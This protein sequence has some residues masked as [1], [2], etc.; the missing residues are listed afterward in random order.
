MVLFILEYVIDASPD[1]LLL[2]RG[3]GYPIVIISITLIQ[4]VPKIII[5]FTNE[6]ALDITDSKLEISETVSETHLYLFFNCNIY[7]N[8][9]YIFL[10]YYLNLIRCLVQ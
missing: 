1:A 4:F 5:M 6:D 7:L 8:T 9:A 2:F 3:I 10:N